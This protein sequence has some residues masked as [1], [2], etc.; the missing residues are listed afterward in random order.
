MGTNRGIGDGR[1]HPCPGKAKLSGAV[2]AMWNPGNQE[3]NPA[4]SVFPAFLNPTF[5]QGG[6]S[7]FML[8]PRLL[9]AAIS[10][11]SLASAA[12]PYQLDKA[13]LGA[14]AARA[15]DARQA[16]IVTVVEKPQASPS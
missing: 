7:H 6:H 12:E 11:P 3:P 16:P 15:P 1:A 10:F 5:N 14:L 4:W 13:G 8:L 2:R 9:L